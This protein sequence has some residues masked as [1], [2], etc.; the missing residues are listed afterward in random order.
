MLLRCDY[1]VRIIFEDGAPENTPS[2]RDTLLAVALPAGA[3]DPR[4]FEIAP[5][6]FDL[7]AALDDWTDPARFGP[8]PHLHALIRAL[9][10]HGL[11]EEHTG[12]ART[13]E[14]RKIEALK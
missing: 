13:S 3:A 8:T 11:V 6:A 12:G 5:V 9:A 2:K 7:L 14:A 10:E 1:D 4:I